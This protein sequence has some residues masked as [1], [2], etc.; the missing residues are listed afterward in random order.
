MHTANAARNAECFAG[1]DCDEAQW[2]AEIQQEQSLLNVTYDL[3]LRS[4]LRRVDAV[5]ASDD[6]ADP[7]Q[8]R[9]TRT[10]MLGPAVMSN[11]AFAFAQ[12]YQL[13]LIVPHEG[14]LFHMYALWYDATAGSITPDQ[15]VGPMIDGLQDTF[16]VIAE[17]CN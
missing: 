2:E 3:N 12:N 16:D 17:R 4:G 13:E 1:G 9:L 15:V 11:N 14:G 5:P 8:A 7:E 6:S 10:F